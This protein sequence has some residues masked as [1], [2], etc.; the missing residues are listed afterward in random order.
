M[1]LSKITNGHLI[2]RIKYFKNKLNDMPREFIYMG[3]SVYAEGAVEAENAH[4]EAL[5]EDIK[6]HI[7]EMEKEAK[8]REI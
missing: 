8:R 6:I 4:N 5:A 7:K 3:D 2:N 1:R